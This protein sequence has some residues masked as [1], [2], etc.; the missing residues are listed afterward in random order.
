MSRVRL[1]I[2][3]SWAL[4]L[5]PVLAGAAGHPPATIPALGAGYLAWAILHRKVVAR[6]GP[7]LLAAALY[8]V[9]AGTL[10]AAGALGSALAGRALSLP[11]WVPPASVVAAALLSRAI[12]PPDRM[13]ELE[14]ML[15]ETLA[16]LEG[17]ARADSARR[18]PDATE[19]RAI[20]ALLT[21]PGPDDA[22]LLAWL[23]RTT[24]PGREGPVLQALWSLRDRPGGARAYLLAQTEP[25]FAE[26]SRGDGL[27]DGAL[28]LAQADPILL[29]LWAQRTVELLDTDR[30]FARDLPPG[31]DLDLA[32]RD[33]EAGTAALLHRL[34]QAR[35]ADPDDP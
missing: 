8:L 20:E 32:A 33:A 30:G 22:A 34:A 9:L 2:W 15:D 35:Q 27:G 13:E 14:R 26:A 7:V 4:L 6:P 21:E 28:A 31:H 5:P 29:A 16:G 11:L 23:D 18:E 25:R 10:W 1:S 12:V 19:V 17:L 3:L 24:R